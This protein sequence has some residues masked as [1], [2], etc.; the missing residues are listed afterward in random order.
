M[1]YW[2]ARK[3]Y[4]HLIP[5]ED[6]K[7]LIEAHYYEDLINGLIIARDTITSRSFTLFSTHTE[8]IRF[9]LTLP[10]NERCFHEVILRDTSFKM[11]FDLDISEEKHRDLFIQERDEFLNVFIQTLVGVYQELYKV[12]LDINRDVIWLD[13]SRPGKISFHIIIDNYRVAGHHEARNL[14]RYILEKIPER[15][16]PFFDQGIYIPNKSL[17]TLGAV[18]DGVGYPLSFVESYEYDGKKVKYQYPVECEGN[19]H[20]SMQYQ[21]SLITVA[22]H[23]SL[24]AEY[25]KV[26]I[27]KQ[28][29]VFIDDD[30]TSKVM[31]QLCQYENTDLIDLPYSLHEVAEGQLRM[32]RLKPSF[33]QVCQ[34]IHD[35]EN[36]YIKVTEKDN[37]LS[38]VFHC[39]RGPGKLIGKLNGIVPI[40][41]MKM[42]DRLG[43]AMRGIGTK[44]DRY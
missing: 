41:D 36:P 17:R 29:V 44:E 21:A 5:T 11:Y 26:E 18:K 27:V 31:T 25:F 40:E 4:Y 15:Y 13:G 42:V 3:W 28:S 7:S 10:S 33:C 6:K 38:I 16:H 1:S 9:L 22:Q 20:I 30:T 8:Y 14:F 23:C 2:K 43:L 37:V 24:L 34:R 19:N 35:A 39:R 32:T 12:I